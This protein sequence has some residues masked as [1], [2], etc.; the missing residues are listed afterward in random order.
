MASFNI[1][2]TSF[3]TTFEQLKPFVHLSNMPTVKPF[4]DSGKLKVKPSGS[5]WSATFSS[6]TKI[7]KH[8]AMWSNNCSPEPSMMCWGMAKIFDFISKCST[9]SSIRRTLKFVPPR[10]S[11][12]N[13]P[14]SGRNNQHFSNSDEKNASM[15]LYHS[16]QHCWYRHYMIVV[17]PQ[18]KSKVIRVLQILLVFFLT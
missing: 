1:C 3:P 5:F 18:K 16:W 9:L 13:F 2:T 7:A 4:C 12:K 11:A 14:V 15:V 17:G 8:S 6:L 10:S